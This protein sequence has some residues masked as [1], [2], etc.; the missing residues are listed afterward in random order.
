VWPF[1]LHPR[2]FHGLDARNSAGEVVMRGF[3]LARRG[4]TLVIGALL[5]SSCRGGKTVKIANDAVRFKAPAA[6]TRTVMRGDTAVELTH[7]RQT[8]T[9]RILDAYMIVLTEK[10]LSH[11]EAVDRLLQIARET[12]A[13]ATFV[14]ID[15]WPALEKRQT[16]VVPPRAA[17][18]SAGR[19]PERQ[20]VQVTTAVAAG[21]IIARVE[22]SIPLEAGAAMVPEVE[23]IGRSLTFA[24]RATAAESESELARLRATAKKAPFAPKPALPE[25]VKPERGATPK[26]LPSTVVNNKKGELEVAATADGLHV[27]VAGQAGNTFFSDDRG[28]TFNPSKITL[29]PMLGIQ[30][31]PSAALGASNAFYVSLL[32]TP[33]GSCNT[34]V[35]RSPPSNGATFTFAGNPVACPSGNNVS[36]PCIPDQPH[37][38]AA[39]KAST[40]GADQLY[41]V[42]RNYGQQDDGTCTSNATVHPTP[43]IVCSSD[44]G[45]TWGQPLLLGAGDDARV[46]VGP[47]GWVWVV[48]RSSEWISV[49]KVSSCESG[50]GL[51]PGF[52][53]ALVKL[54]D[55]VCPVAGLDRCSGPSLSSATIAVDQTDG[56]HVYIAYGESTSHTND[57]IRVIDTTDGF[58]T[59]PATLRTVTINNPVTGRRFMPWVCTLG[60]TAQVGWYD[61]SG[62]S[63]GK[64]DRT[65]YVRGSAAV[66]GGALTS[67][68]QVTVSGSADRQCDTGFPCGER[69]LADA[70]TCPTAQNDGTCKNAGGAGSLTACD[71]DRPVCPPGEKCFGNGGNSGCPKY[72]DYNG[73]ACAA[74]HVFAAWA[75]GTAPP[76]LPPPGGI[77]IFVDGVTCGFIGLP[78]CLGGDACQSGTC[79]TTTGLCGD[80]ACGG[81]G[82]PCCDG[83][84]CVPDSGCSAGTCVSCPKPFTL[85]DG[86]VQNN[87]DCG[88]TDHSYD[89]GMRACTP[90]FVLRT[91]DAGLNSD[92]NG[93]TCSATPLT[94]SCACRVRVTTPMDCTKWARCRV[95]VTEEPISP[96]GRPI[97]CP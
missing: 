12:Q 78:C 2:P 29:P 46:T 97:G 73:I 17:P 76:G 25:K 11:A 38:A 44:G 52:P 79:N 18:E 45:A 20:V 35:L 40:T 82:Q 27:V 70:D 36:S 16:I 7:S 43:R 48:F 31:D 9:G 64:E 74:G 89:L 66:V 86:E 68:A 81:V 34:S 62:A 10:R 3:D 69:N 72:G 22:T 39:P 93:S 30:G 92:L 24:A 58:A 51:Q 47:D 4:G 13:P 83:N 37:M 95:L 55:P 33:G 67:G 14:L 61:R 54:F 65:T 63:A 15:G 59:G 53:K 90:G 49:A 50:L 71:Q 21:D 60:A 26:G 42:Y 8:S 6:W 91:C 1:V 87:P 41:V 57:E 56:N 19:G 94:G 85:F 80:P 96:G 77:G 5:A 23:T 28:V 32:T 75:S 84:N 88:S